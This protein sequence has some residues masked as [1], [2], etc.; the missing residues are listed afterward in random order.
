M[1]YKCFFI[2]IISIIFEK[3]K[4]TNT[5]FTWIKLKFIFQVVKDLVTIF[6][7]LRDWMAEFLAG[8]CQMT[9][10]E[11][12]HNLLIEQ[13]PKVISLTLALLSSS[14]LSFTLYCMT[15]WTGPPS[16]A[17]LGKVWLLYGYG[18]R[19]TTVDSVVKSVGWNP[20]CPFS[21]GQRKG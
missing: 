9:A 6:P 4:T 18:R 10:S 8:N 13:V 16:P 14:L 20:W 17:T 21:K 1:V 2:L 12:G 15:Y 7:V 5:I 11:I 19:Q 3:K